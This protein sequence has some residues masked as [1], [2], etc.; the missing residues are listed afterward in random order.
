MI[1]ASLSS[2][3]QLHSRFPDTALG[4]TRWRKGNQTVLLHCRPHLASFLP[5]SID[6]FSPCQ[7]GKRTDADAS[8]SSPFFP[9]I[10]PLKRESA[11]GN[12]CSCTGESLSDSKP[13]QE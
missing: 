12:A 2:V 5:S 11:I 10:S 9:P 6:I 1:L 3:T 4:G 7:I 8:G 13:I